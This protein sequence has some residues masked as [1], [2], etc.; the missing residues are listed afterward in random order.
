MPDRID[1]APAPADPPGQRQ[2]SLARMAEFGIEPKR[3]LGQNFLIDDNI[4]R[5]I[6]DRLDPNPEDVVIEVG[7]GLGILTRALAAVTANVHAFEIDRSLGPA[8]EATLA[9]AGVSGRVHLEYSD[10]MRVSL[11]GLVPPP[12]LCASNLPYSIAAPFLGEALE[13][14]PSIRRY[15]VMTQREVAER[16]VSPPGSKAYG[17]PSV[18]AQ[19]H[20]RIV[21]IRPLSRTIFH[22][23]PNVDS[24][25]ITLER[26]VT[27]PFVTEHPVVVRAVVEGTFQQRRKF[28]LNSLSAVLGVEKQQVGDVLDRA[29]VS[30]S[31]RPEQMEPAA[32]VAVARALVESGLSNRYNEPNDGAGS[33]RPAT[34]RIGKRGNRSR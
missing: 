20:V 29:G 33:G 19:L 24:S 13:H 9:D 30:V 11:Q 3:S 31:T 18:W 4:I 14:L 2:V 23:R 28:V 7:A 1:D 16:L 10:I 15:C 25:L 17:A 6:I 5:V 21:E 32:F 22:P 26:A 27:D 12:T 8:L 34:E